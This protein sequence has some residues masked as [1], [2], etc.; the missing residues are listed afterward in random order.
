MKK[1]QK[2]KRKMET[3]KEEETT[4]TIPKKD[5]DEKIGENAKALSEA[6]SALLFTKLNELCLKLDEVSKKQEKIKDIIEKENNRMK[7]VSEL[8]ALSDF[9]K[10][11]SK[12]PE[13]NLRA[14]NLRGDM[15]ELNE[16][17]DKL[18]KRTAKLQQKKEKY[19][20]EFIENERRLMAVDVSQ[21]K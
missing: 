11:V 2:E 4:T 15:A 17:I 8:K 12:L 5:T 14:I 13:Y 9:D 7:E 6:S 20:A 16:R 3:P 21:T 18:K 10:V 19:D 1:N